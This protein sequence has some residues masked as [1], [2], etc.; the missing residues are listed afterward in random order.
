VTLRDPNRTTTGARLIYT[1]ADERYVITGTPV[2]VIDQ[3]KRETSGSTVT[4]LKSSETVTVDGNEQTRTQ[5][6][7]SGQCP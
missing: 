6:K 3:C 4:Y 1:T 2:K 5:T 7:G